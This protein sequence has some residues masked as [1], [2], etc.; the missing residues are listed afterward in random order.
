MFRLNRL[1]ASHLLVHL[2]QPG[3]ALVHELWFEGASA[4][5]R[6]VDLNL[7]VTTQ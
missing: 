6:C 4:V 3:L 2:C 5:A 7:S 1:S